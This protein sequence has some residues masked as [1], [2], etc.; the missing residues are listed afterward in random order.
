TAARLTHRDAA[1]SEAFEQQ[2]IDTLLKKTIVFLTSANQELQIIASRLTEVTKGCKNSADQEKA[3]TR[4]A[5]LSAL[6]TASPIMTNAQTYDSPDQ[7]RKALAD[8][9]AKK[10]K[11]NQ[12][13]DQVSAAMKKFPRP[14]VTSQ[15]QQSLTDADT[16]A[17]KA[18]YVKAFDKLQT[19]LT[20]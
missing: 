17:K 14:W 2:E 7:V 20:D 11:Y 16:A 1:A 4:A 10:L 12:R 8:A 6:R 13:M 9:R 18:D 19:A 3:A 5:A 15:L